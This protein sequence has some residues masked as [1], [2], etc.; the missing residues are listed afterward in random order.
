MT[1]TQAP[2]KG[3][4]VI[5]AEDET[6][7][8]ILMRVNTTTRDGIVQGRWELD[9][10]LKPVA[11]ESPLENCLVNLGPSPR[12]GTV[13]G[14]D[15]S[16]LY[17]KSVQV[18]DYGDMHIFT[19]I[20]KEI[21]SAFKT[22]ASEVASL[23]KKHGIAEILNSG[24]VWQL[25]SK[26]TA[27]NYAGWYQP[28]KLT[29]DGE[30]SRPARISLTLD[31]ETLKSSSIDN[32]SYVIA[33]E[34]GHAVHLQTVK[35]IEG[36]D[37]KW[38]RLY[39]DTVTP[40]KVPQSEVL[41]MRD[42]LISSGA[43]F[44]GFRSTLEEEKLDT[45]KVIVNEIRRTSRLS[46]RE[47]DT[48]TQSEDAGDHIRRVWPAS[49]VYLSKLSPLLTQYSLKNYHELFAE[50]F[51]FYLLGKKLP[52]ELSKL[53]ERTLSKVRAAEGWSL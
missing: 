47:L 42:E 33:H 29:K 28:S 31:E 5:F 50:T 25:V 52:S 13:Y 1:K 9:P 18:P 53:M 8:P 10:H 6:S 12:P 22:G 21:R 49:S 37:E 48:L 14:K 19:S 11:V 35:R 26:K 46:L 44:S 45:F 36:L 17:R 3:D 15:L 38:L 7:P 51:A 20:S 30:A 34:L 4:Y 41:K 23:L 43:P 2:S 27:G 32:Y 24:I 39:T 16:F 40:V